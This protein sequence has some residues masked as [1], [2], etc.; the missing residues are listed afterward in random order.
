MVMSLR[1]LLCGLESVEM[2]ELSRLLHVVSASLSWRYHRTSSVIRGLHVRLFDG[3]G[4]SQI[5]D[6]EVMMIDSRTAYSEKPIEYYQE[7]ISC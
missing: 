6:A 5:H 3:H 1:F 4:S 7:M 2:S